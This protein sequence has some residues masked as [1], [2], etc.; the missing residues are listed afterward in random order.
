ML[1]ALW[2]ITVVPNID[3]VTHGGPADRAVLRAGD[4][5]ELGRMSR[6]DR[7]TS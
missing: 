5:V 4:R 3:G 7:L 6:R 2:L 1:T